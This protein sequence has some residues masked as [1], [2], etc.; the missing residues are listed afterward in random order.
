MKNP[1]DIF[2]MLKQSKRALS[3]SSVTTCDVESMCPNVK[4]D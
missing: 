4:T 3:S 1:D 2:R